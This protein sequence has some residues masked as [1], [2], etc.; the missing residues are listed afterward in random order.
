[1]F[2]KLERPRHNIFFYGGSRY[3]FINSHLIN[4]ISIEKNIIVIKMRDSMQNFAFIFNE[5]NI[6][7]LSKIID[8]TPI[9]H[10]GILDC[11]TEKP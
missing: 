11:I 9:K 8:I 4:A 5:E 3:Y 2:L 7:E 10:N 6:K 1:M